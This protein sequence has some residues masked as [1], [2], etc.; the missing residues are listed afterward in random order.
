MVLNAK[1]PVRAVPDLSDHHVTI[2]NRL[3]S[4]CQRD[5]TVEGRIYRC[6]RRGYLVDFDG[7]TGFLPGSHLDVLP[8]VDI[9][10]F[11]KCPSYFKVLRCNAL[12][13]RLVV[14]RR[15]TLPALKI[16]AV[17]LEDRFCVGQR[18]TGTVAQ[19]L[20]YGTFV[21]LG[22]AIMGFLPHC[23][24]RP[25]PGD[26]V[27]VQIVRLNSDSQRIVLAAAAVTG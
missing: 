1:D 22:D 13:G 21:D 26:P 19:N 11:L 15:A 9:A 4:A 12:H 25:N 24:P 23:E 16:N 6:V 8:V 18:L 5:E 7:V 17:K 2:W 20:P 3:Q 10:P 27:A 14:S